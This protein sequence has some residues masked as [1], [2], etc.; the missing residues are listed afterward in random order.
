MKK[1]VSSLMVGIAV[2]SFTLPS[3]AASTVYTEKQLVGLK[4]INQEGRTV[5]EIQ[6]VNHDVKTGEM[7]SVTLKAAPKERDRDDSSANGLMSNP[8]FQDRDKAVGG[9]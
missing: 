4:I 3:F 9:M 1:I 5:G 7:I 8:M 2:M 6:S